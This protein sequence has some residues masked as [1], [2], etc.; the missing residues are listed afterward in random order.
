MLAR[1]GWQPLVKI[2]HYHLDAKKIAEDLRRTKPEEA[3]RSAVADEFRLFTENTDFLKAEMG[4]RV[5][6]FRSDDPHRRDPANRADLA[7][8]GRPAIYVE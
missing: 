5:D 3:E 6:A 2:E 4:C 8:P 1:L 7:V